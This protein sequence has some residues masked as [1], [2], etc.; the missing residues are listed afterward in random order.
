MH[1]HVETEDLH[2]A[3]ALAGCFL[4]AKENKSNPSF[5]CSF[6]PTTPE[7]ALL[8]EHFQNKPSEFIRVSIPSSETEFEELDALADQ[9]QKAMLERV[10]QVVIE[11]TSVSKLPINEL[12]SVI[13]SKD[14]QIL[15]RGKYWYPNIGKKLANK[16]S[17]FVGFSEDTSLIPYTE[18]FLKGYKTPGK[19]LDLSDLPVIERIYASAGVCSCYTCRADSKVLPVLRAWYKGY[20]HMKEQVPVLVLFNESPPDLRRAVPFGSQILMTESS[21]TSMAFAKGENWALRRSC[22]F[23]ALEYI[24]R[25][26]KNEIQ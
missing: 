4:D 22:N 2:W 5:T 8:A 18:E 1:L 6:E 10:F 25:K 23:D 13:L 24:R 17:D 21:G 12:A 7:I 11:K 15:S 19:V 14:Y 20:D 3:S 26:A 9:E 16:Y